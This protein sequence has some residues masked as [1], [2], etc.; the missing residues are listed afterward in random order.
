ME[1]SE[2]EKASFPKVLSL[3]FLPAYS[4]PSSLEY[5]IHEGKGKFPHYNIA[6][7]WNSAWNI[8]GTGG[9]PPLW[10]KDD[11]DDQNTTALPPIIPS[12]WIHFTSRESWKPESWDHRVTPAFECQFWTHPTSLLYPF[13]SVSLR[14]D[15][16]TQSALSSKE[17]SLKRS[18]CS[19]LG[20]LNWMSPW[21]NHLWIYTSPLVRVSVVWRFYTCA[22]LSGDLGSVPLPVTDTWFKPDSK[23]LFVWP[24]EVWR[25]TGHRHREISSYMN[26]TGFLHCP[27]RVSFISGWKATCVKSGQDVQRKHEVCTFPVHHPS[28]SGNQAHGALHFH[29]SGLGHTSVFK[30][31]TGKG[32]GLNPRRWKDTGEPSCNCCIYYTKYMRQNKW[33]NRPEFLLFTK[34]QCSNDKIPYLPNKREVVK[35]KPFVWCNLWNHWSIFSKQCLVTWEILI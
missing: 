8:T 2:S 25:E 1:K 16:E 32:D 10:I 9:A 11:D 28:E 22:H 14:E 26:G 35:H 24:L 15:E 7:I 21:A 12:R 30:P 31:G 27:L 5:K 6:D 19:S 33:W 3:L 34:I 4:L 13:G 17:V 23:W 18:W 20:S 29:W